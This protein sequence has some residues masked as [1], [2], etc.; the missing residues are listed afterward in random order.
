[1]PPDTADPNPMTAAALPDAEAVA[2]AVREAARAHALPL[3]GNLKPGDVREKRPN[4][5][6][7]AADLAVEA[8]LRRSLDALA[9]GA[10]FV[11]EESYEADPGSV[12]R[13]RGAE[14][15]WIV[16][17]VDGTKNF[18]AG[19]P[20]FAVIVAFARFGETAMGWIYDPVADSMLSAVKGQGAMLDGAPVQ[21]GDAGARKHGVGFVAKSLRERMTARPPETWPDADAA[22]DLPVRLRCAGQEYRSLVSGEAAFIRF[23]GRPKPWDH[24]AGTLIVTEAGGRQGLIDHAG[25]PYQPGRGVEDATLLCAATPAAWDAAHAWM[26]RV[27]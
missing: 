4:D 24:A 26:A 11:G 8:A 3:F 17:P 19:E 12:D 14:A 9:P 25:Q 20:C 5:P 2:A 22:P 1:M 6:V 27:D 21:R 16:D 7:T 18:A 10:V 23:G 13:L 15:A